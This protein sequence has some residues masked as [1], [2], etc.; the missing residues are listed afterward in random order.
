MLQLVLFILWQLRTKVRCT[1]G[2]KQ[3]WVNLV[4]VATEKYELQ[5]KLSSLKMY[6][7]DNVLQG[8][9]TQSL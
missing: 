1:V 6:K 4:S 7:L 5:D 3:R 9:A 2:V 8:M